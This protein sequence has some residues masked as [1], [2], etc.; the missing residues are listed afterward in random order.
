M[1]T[2][3]VKIAGFEKT[4]QI[5]D[6]TIEEFLKISVLKSLFSLNRYNEL[7]RMQTMESELHLDI[8]DA[9]AYISVFVENHDDL[10]KELGAK[11]KSVAELP[12]K[13]GVVIRKIGKLIEPFYKE[14]FEDYKEILPK[15][16]D[17]M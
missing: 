15:E 10:L 12:A 3:N 7:V 16:V 2:I 5:K 6:I 17:S 14:I 9:I 11:G 1:A 13:S 4:L 8:I